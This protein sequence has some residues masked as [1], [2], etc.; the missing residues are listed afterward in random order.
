MLRDVLRFA[1]LAAA[2]VLALGA[3][4]ISS[5]RA[6]ETF[7]YVVTYIETMPSAEKQAAQVIDRYGAS[8]REAA[9]NLRFQALQR[10]DRPNQFAFVSAWKDQKAAEAFAAAAA[11]QQFR[12]KLT[13]FLSAPIDE[14]PYSGLEVGSTDVVGSIPSVRKTRGAVYVVTHV[15]IIPP[16]KDDGIAALKEI[17]G[18]SRREAGNRRYEVLQQNSRP[19]HFTLVEIW[20][21][22]KALEAHEV[23]A[24]TLKLR[25]TLLPMG[26]ALFDQRLYHAMD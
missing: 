14:R 4:G 19:N 22:Q 15:D 3:V 24:H 16:K 21:N 8:G 12:D 23:A 2:A 11:T 18:P 9:G 5:A 13:P 10:V 25:Q 6:Q 7:A 20:H 26:G 1:T 17:S